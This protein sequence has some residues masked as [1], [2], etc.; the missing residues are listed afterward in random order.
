MHGIIC[1]KDDL[2]INLLFIFF[3]C[4]IGP[5][6]AHHRCA[7]NFFLNFALLKIWN[8][9]KCLVFQILLIILP[10]YEFEVILYH[11]G[12]YFGGSVY[13]CGLVSSEVQALCGLYPI[14]RSLGFII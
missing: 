11:I 3:A 7:T 2:H 14:Y 1:K 13:E 6:I 8:I 5:S 12:F 9:I 4:I 10:K